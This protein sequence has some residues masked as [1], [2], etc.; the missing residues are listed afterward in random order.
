MRITSIVLFALCTFVFSNCKFAKKTAAKGAVFTP[1][2]VPGPPAM[3]YKTNADYSNLVP[4]S[5][6]DSGTRIL[7]YPAPE[8]VKAMGIAILKPLQL[9]NHYWLDNAGISKNTAYLDYTWEIYQTLQNLTAESLLPHV[10]YLKPFKEICNCGLKTEMPQL[11]KS[12]NRLI[13]D[14]K[15][16]TVCKEN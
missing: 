7:S 4:V 14:G 12:I 3:V 2:L 5:M 8:D 13:K 11:E 9:R 10:K 6:N 1:V 15:L 16:K